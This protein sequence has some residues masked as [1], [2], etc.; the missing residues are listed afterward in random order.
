MK[1]GRK[2]F[3]SLLAVGV[4]YAGYILWMQGRYAPSVEDVQQAVTASLRQQVPVEIIQAPPDFGVQ[5]GSQGRP[6]SINVNKIGRKDVDEKGREF[7]LVDVTVQGRCSARYSKGEGALSTE[8]RAFAGK[9]WYRMY[10]TVG[11]GAQL[12]GDR[13]EW[14]AV[15]ERAAPFGTG[16]PRVY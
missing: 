12:T 7:W 11:T 3:L 16:R 13:I 4:L 5:D 8:Q 14:Q 1:L 9:V 6:D 15:P 10:R 2:I